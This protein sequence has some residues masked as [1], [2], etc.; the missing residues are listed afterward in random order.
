MI[1]VKRELCIIFL[2]TV[3]FL[4]GC[5]DMHQET[6]TET[7]GDRDFTDA[8]QF[9]QEEEYARLAWQ[10][11]FDSNLSKYSFA[12]PDIADFEE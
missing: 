6:A 9:D 11:G 7:L 2:L 12:E 3:S 1:C 5:A 4:C 8:Y 10:V